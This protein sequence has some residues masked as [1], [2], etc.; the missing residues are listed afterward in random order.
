MESFGDG[1]ATQEI[2]RKDDM[3]LERLSVEVDDYL[4]TVCTSYQ[5]TFDREY[6]ILIY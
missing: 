4:Q 1:L 2:A 3:Y 5:D 6:Q